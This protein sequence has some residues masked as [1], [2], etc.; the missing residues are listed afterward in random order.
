MIVSDLNLSENLTDHSQ[1][2]PSKYHSQSAELNAINVDIWLNFGDEFSEGEYIETTF[3]LPAD[4]ELHDLKNMLGRQN[5]HHI[6]LAHLS[7]GYGTVA[8]LAQEDEEMHDAFQK[9]LFNHE[10]CSQFDQICKTKSVHSNPE[11]LLHKSAE[12]FP[13]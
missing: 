13:F 2:I 1:D 10:F 12:Y 11:I 8:K 4:V 9:L 7:Y 5:M 3:H 6:G